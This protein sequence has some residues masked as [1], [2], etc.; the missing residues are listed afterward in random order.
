MGFSLPI[1]Y[2]MVSGYLLKDFGRFLP[3]YCLLDPMMVLTI[4]LIGVYIIPYVLMGKN[5]V[6]EILELVGYGVCNWAM[7]GNFRVMMIEMEWE[8]VMIVIFK[9]SK[10]IEVLFYL[11]FGAY[12]RIK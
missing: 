4:C 7:V 12:Y 9:L 3:L 5:S 2:L 8:S 1:F 10:L 11:G 6:P